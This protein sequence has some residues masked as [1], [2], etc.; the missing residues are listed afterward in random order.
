MGKTSKGIEKKMS[1]KWWAR[2]TQFKGFCFELKAIID[3]KTTKKLRQNGQFHHVYGKLIRHLFIEKI[4]VSAYNFFVSNP[5]QINATEAIKTVHAR[6]SITRYL[7]IN[8]MLLWFNEKIKLQRIIQ[9]QEKAIL[10][11]GDSMGDKGSI[12]ELEDLRAVFGLKRIIF[13]MLSQRQK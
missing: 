7:N 2:L 1:Y 5:F 6:L 4:S 8:E 12:F 3:K 11:T 9:W 10:L 13:N